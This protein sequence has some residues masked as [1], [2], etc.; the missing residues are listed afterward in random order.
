MSGWLTL[1]LAMSV[2]AVSAALVLAILSA[3]R[4]LEHVIAI[5]TLVE[6][7]L[8]PLA[9]EARGLASDARGLTQE[10]T[11]ELRRTGEVLDQVHEAASGVAR[12]V[13]AMATLTRAG[14]LV[15]I[16]TGL[17]RGLD[18]FVERFRKNGGNH[19]EQ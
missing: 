19:H 4:T 13:N 3:R 11:R 2:L 1:A 16:A 15:G 7:E 10:T 8:G 5:L 9:T 6:R 14:Q 12:V 18:V 17:R